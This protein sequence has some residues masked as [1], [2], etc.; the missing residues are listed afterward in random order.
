MKVL[1]GSC[2][3]QSPEILSEFLKGLDELKKP[4]NVEYYFIEHNLSEKSK[5]VLHNWIMKHD[6]VHCKNIHD[7]TN[8]IKDENTTHQWTREIVDKI[9]ELKNHI[10]KYAKQQDYDYLFLTDSDQIYHPDTLLHLIERN[11]DVIGE[12]SWTKW[13]P[14]QLEMPNAWIKHPYGFNDDSLTKLREKNLVEVAG[15]GGCYLINREVLNRGISFTRTDSKTNWGEDRYFH[16]RAKQLGFT[17]YIDTVYPYFHIYRNT[18][19]M[20]IATWK[21][22]GYKN[23][24]LEIRL[25]SVLIA[26][27]VGE[28]E[29][30]PET[31][32]WITKTLLK[33]SGWGLDISRGHPIDSNRNQVVKKFMTL[34]EAQCFEWLLFCDSD[35]VPPDNAVERLL[36]H[37]K[38]IIGGVC[39]IMSGKGLPIPNFSKELT[40]GRYPAELIEVKGMGAGFMLIHRDVL[41]DVGKSPFRFRYDDWGIANISG[42]DYDFCEKATKKGYKIYVDLGVQCEHYKQ[43][44]LMSLNNRLANIIT[45]IREDEHRSEEL[46]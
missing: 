33:N 31:A 20:K 46:S 14:N 37:G 8:Y 40:G 32:A 27:C 24:E 25:G 45:E 5:T 10:L 2:I 26:I 41:N 44:G 18:D 22:N 3:R 9:I 11:L 4:E 36:F 23:K 6:K 21:Q 30:H 35:V 42:E 39:F 28:K 7:K 29:I 13:T 43:T 15:F 16:M 12:I 17:S 34:P 1:I 19:L 38:K